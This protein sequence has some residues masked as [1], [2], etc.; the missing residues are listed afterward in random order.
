MLTDTGVGNLVKKNKKKIMLTGT[1]IF[2]SRVL[3]QWTMQ[4]F[5]CLHASFSVGGMLLA[6]TTESC[7]R[8]ILS[9]SAWTSVKPGFCFLGRSLNTSSDCSSSW[10]SWGS[11]LFTQQ[12]VEEV[13]QHSLISSPCFHVRVRLFDRGHR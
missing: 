4:P 9:N 8:V 1:Y 6:E 12:T 5:C 11:S 13:G 3:T 10:T 7:L 2:F